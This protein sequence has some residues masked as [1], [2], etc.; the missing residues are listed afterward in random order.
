MSSNLP[1]PVALSRAEESE[2]NQVCA[3]CMAI[4]HL[5]ELL[6]ELEGKDVDEE[7]GGGK[8]IFILHVEHG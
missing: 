7:R 8:Q 6:Y 2:Y 5:K 1:Q 4:S 3:A